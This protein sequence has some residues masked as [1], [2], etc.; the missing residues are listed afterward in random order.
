MMVPCEYHWNKESKPHEKDAWK[1]KKI[2]MKKK[3]LIRS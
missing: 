3:Y 2:R 1:N